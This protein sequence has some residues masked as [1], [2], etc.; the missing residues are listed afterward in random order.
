MHLLPWKL[1]ALECQFHLYV[2]GEQLPNV[3]MSEYNG[4]VVTHFINPHLFWYIKSN[5]DDKKKLKI[6][7]K[8][9]KVVKAAVASGDGKHF[10]AGLGDIFGVFY[11]NKWIRA[12]IDQVLLDGNFIVWAIDYGRP[13]TVNQKSMVRIDEVNAEAAIPIY[14]GGSANCLPVDSVCIELVRDE[15]ISA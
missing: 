8:L 6:E 13:I 11:E 15:N 1:F 12:E 5:V 10:H 2:N 3:K 14:M 9:L 7:K 4:I